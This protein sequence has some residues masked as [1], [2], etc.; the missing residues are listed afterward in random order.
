MEIDFSVYRFM[1]ESKRPLK[2]RGPGYDELTMEI[3]PCLV[4]VGK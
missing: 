1:F 3:L 2:E 4:G